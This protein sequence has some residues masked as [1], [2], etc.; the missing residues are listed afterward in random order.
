MPEPR[1]TVE[2]QA[3]IGHATGPLRVIAG[4]GTGKTATMTEHIAQAISDGRVPGEIVALTFTNAAAAELTERVA[5]RLRTAKLGLWTG[6]YHSF[7]AQ[8]VS[9]GAAALDLP[10]EPRLLSPVESWLAVRSIIVDGIE[11]EATDLM[12]FPESVNRFVRL[13]SGCKDDL[14]SPARLDDYIHSL[15]ADDAEHAAEMRDLRRV[16]EAYTSLCRERGAI[17]YGDQITLAIEALTSDQMLLEAYRERYKVYVV[18]EYQD[19]NYAQAELVRILSAPEHQLRVVGDPN[20]SIYRFRGAAVENIIDFS[21][22]YPNVQTV[23]LSTNFRSHQQILNAANALVQNTLIPTELRANGDRTGPRPVLAVGARWADEITWIAQELVKAHDADGASEAPRPWREMA[24][25]VR[26][27]K[28]LRDIAGAL[29]DVG[30]PYQVRAGEALFELDAVR[31]IVAVLRFLADPSDTP[32]LIRMLTSPRWGVELGMI[33]T[34]REHL[35]PASLLDD[36][37][38]VAERVSVDYIDGIGYEMAASLCAFCDELRAMMRAVVGLPVHIAVR[39]IIARAG[40]LHT[41]NDLQA[42]D[43]LATLADDFSGNLFDPSLTRF[44]EYLEAL[45]ALEGEEATVPLP[46]QDD[47]VSIVTVHGAKGLEFDVVVVA[48]LNA[49]DFGGGPV[50]SDQLPA[51]LRHNARAYPVRDEFGDREGYLEAVKET[52]KQFGKDEERRLLYVAL[53]RPREHLL[54]C[55]SQQHPS[56]KRETKQYGLID[57]I[58]DVTEPATIPL[59]NTV[60]LRAPLR[61]FIEATGVPLDASNGFGSMPELWSAYWRSSETPELAVLA[62]TAVEDFERMVPARRDLIEQLR[63]AD[64]VEP[65]ISSGGGIVSYSQLSAYERCPRVF[66]LRY[67][68]GV[69]SRPQDR[70][71]MQLGSAFHDALHGAHLAADYSQ[72]QFRQMFVSALGSDAEAGS[73]DAA[74]RIVDGFFA[75][76]D[77]GHTP[78]AV[79]QEFFLNITG[80]PGAPIIRGFIDRIQKRNDGTV[81]IV[82]YKTYR[83]AL[84][85]AQVLADLQ[86]PIYVLACQRSLPWQPD[87]ATMAFVRHGLWERF[88]IDELNLDGAIACIDQLLEGMRAGAFDCT[89]GGVEC[90][91]I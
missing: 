82:D 47:A 52:D 15:P 39:R 79:E 24:V 2:Q 29:D 12:Q 71:M 32:S 75:S 87:I 35:R 11:I 70:W 40:L 27:R 36:L 57:E 20:Q 34:L 14:V 66:F 68:V 8:I 74:Q 67:V 59:A 28:L 17:D 55:W 9:E 56:R 4:A 80:Q 22:Q 91:R 38:R 25:L 43:Q 41:R 49:N 19:T 53:T 33:Y 37:N 1:W 13:I 7:G 60:R 77:A 48:G 46:P 85:R 51:A 6:T 72:Q 89:C 81:E 83:T 64:T 73:S 88:T 50:S 3:A 61:E 90:S 65:A 45:A 62:A 18:D 76:G 78:L 69:P 86:L 10:A 21:E 84:S 26:K 31:D 58:V 63:V 54:M 42:L 44:V 30:V 16:F 5:T 23:R